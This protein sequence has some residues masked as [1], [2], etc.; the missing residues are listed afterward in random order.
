MKKIRDIVAVVGTYADS[1]G[2]QKNQYRNVGSLLQDDA[3]KTRLA[4]AFDGLPDAAVLHAAKEGKDTI[5]LSLFEPRER[6]QT[7]NANHD[8]AA[9]A[10]N[11]DGDD[12]PF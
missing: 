9:Q 8:R 10:A 1:Q 5:W 3:D 4:I 2:N 6:E 11:A 7:Q 12:I